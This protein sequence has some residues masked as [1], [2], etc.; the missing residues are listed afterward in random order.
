MF[1]E[2]QYARN[3]DPASIDALVYQSE[4]LVE[5][6]KNESGSESLD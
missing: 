3:D 4:A 5:I 1:K 2:A 6:G